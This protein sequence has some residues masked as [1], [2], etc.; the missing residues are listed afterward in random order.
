MKARLL[1]SQ[2]LR[3]WTVVHPARNVLWLCLDYLTAALIITGTILFWNHSASWGLHWI[4]NVAVGFIAVILNGAVQHRIA[5]MGHEASHYMLHPNR[6][7][8]DLLGELLCFFPIF[9]TLSHYRAKHL[10]HHLYPNDPERDPNMAGSRARRLYSRFPMPKP[11][12]VYNYYVKFFW[13]PFVFRNLVDLMRVITIGEGFSPLPADDGDGNHG[14]VG[15][16]PFYQNSSVLGIGYLVLFIAAC[17][18]AVYYDSMALLFG[19]LGG[20]YLFGL[21][22]LVRLPDSWIQRPGGRLAYS[23]RFSSFL[24]LTFY[25]VLFAILGTIHVSSGVWAGGYFILL[26]VLSLV[27]ALPYFMLLREIF[28]HAN[29]D[30]G[31]LTNSRIIHA[32]PFTQWALLGY[33]NHVH[34]VHHIYPNIPHY[35]LLDAHGRMMNDCEAYGQSAEETHGL[36]AAREGRKSLL[37][38]LAADPPRE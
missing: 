8:N 19:L 11:S 37:D 16:R 23:P 34:L 1:D 31:E 15:E 26:W 29:A 2:T 6:K 28:Q 18:T 17:H 27:Y 21:A 36:F 4:W 25:S 13:P 3:K 7:V 5:L 24:R 35:C 33:G 20:I 38:S 22:V 10:G 12:F 9:A 14:T 30:E 32:D